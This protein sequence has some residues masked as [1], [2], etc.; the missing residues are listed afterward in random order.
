MPRFAP[1]K[2]E[3]YFAQYEFKARYLLS[4]SDCE[5]LTLAEL[6]KLADPASR[7]LWDALSLGYTESQG[8]PDLRGEITQLYTALTADEVLVVTPEEGI[9][10]ALQT[11]LEPGDHVVALTP[12]YQSLAE[13]ARASGG[14][15]SAWPLRAAA[16]R[17][18]LDLEQLPALLTP[19]TKLLVLNFPN[20]PTGF[21]PTRAEF[22][23]V[24]ALAQARGIYVFSDEM[25][26]WLEPDLA[27]RLPAAAD[28]YERGITLAGL[29]KA[30]ALPGLRL[31]WLAAREPGLVDRWLAFKDY[32][33]ICH[34]APSE[35]LALMALRAREKI[36]ARNVAIVR[37]NRAHAEAFCAEHPALFEWLSPVA[38]SIAF[39]RWTGP[40]PVE[41]LCQALVDSHGVMVAPGHLFEMAGGHFRLGLGR[42]NLPLALTQVRA[43]LRVAA[44]I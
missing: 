10:I 32:T 42:R 5:S 40:G 39:P 31:G 3:R 44:L 20:N 30:F 29:S 18:H 8:H 17:W 9:F 22:D 38:G 14:T 23:A 28:V 1:F 24:L 4:A 25:Y 41:G 19:H 26:R 12:A 43:Y 35:I 37:A 27:L 34:N 33:T 13:V 36:L 16:G 2:L 21:L 15:V 7:A 11:L 6:L